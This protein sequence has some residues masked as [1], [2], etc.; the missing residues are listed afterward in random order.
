M[1]LPAQQRVSYAD[2][3]ALEQQTG[4]KHE[5]LDGEVLAMAGGSA[6]H[7]LIAANLTISLGLQLRGTPC[8]PFTSDWK[9]WMEKA[10]RAAYPDLSVICDGIVRPHHDKNAATNPT[11]VVEVL[12][13]STED[14]DRGTKARDYLDLPSLQALVFVDSTR[15]RV[16][17]HT[18]NPDHSWTRRVLGPG[19]TLT[20]PVPAV[21]VPVNELY[22]EVEFLEAEAD[23]EA[24]AGAPEGS[25]PGDDGPHA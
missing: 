19:A 11:L 14:H 17:V 12:S 8:R 7:S 23:S 20:L 15:V 10:N 6:D 4:H 18:R 24:D 2:Y 21:A 5:F 22:A 16:E 9:I 3:L 25:A 13:P 1:G